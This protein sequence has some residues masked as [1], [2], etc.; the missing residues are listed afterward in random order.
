[1]TLLIV[2]KE[3]FKMFGKSF[4]KSIYKVNNLPYNIINKEI[5]MSWGLRIHLYKMS[6]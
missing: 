4:K 3:L 6:S 5:D 1:M 2:E